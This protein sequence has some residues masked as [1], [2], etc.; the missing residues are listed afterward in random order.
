MVESASKETGLGETGR[1]ERE[2]GEAYGVAS[3]ELFLG[4]YDGSRSLGLV[5]GSFAADDSLACGGP[6]AGLA[7]DLSYGIP[8]VRH[9]Y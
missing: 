4:G 2:I 7:A 1:R 5:Q 6:T 8:V 3:S 9:I